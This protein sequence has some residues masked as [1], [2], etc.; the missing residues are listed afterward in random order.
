[1]GSNF[2]AVGARGLS[3]K[4]MPTTKRRFQP[5][6]LKGP[7][8]HCVAIQKKEICS[9]QSASICPNQVALCEKPHCGKKWSRREIRSV[10]TTNNR[11]CG[12]PCRTCRVQ[13]INQSALTFLDVRTLQIVVLSA[14]GDRKS[15]GH[16]KKGPRIA[17][18]CRSV[19]QYSAC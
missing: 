13:L 17:R 16:G 11:V 9:K 18:F 3:T 6:G 10:L 1:M 12:K 19:V 7:H 8:L 14:Q 2:A 5:R 15:Y 4:T